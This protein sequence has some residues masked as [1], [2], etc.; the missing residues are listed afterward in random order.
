M[1]NVITFKRKVDGGQA[2]ADAHID[3]VSYAQLVETMIGFVKLYLAED[4]AGRHCDEL[5]RLTLQ[6]ERLARRVTP[7][8]GNA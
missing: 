8:K 7:P 6:L 4:D 2:S 3:S 1:G 5:A